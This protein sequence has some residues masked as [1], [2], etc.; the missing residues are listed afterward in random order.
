MKKIPCLFQRDFSDRRRPVLLPEVTP[1][2]LAKIVRA[3]NREA[4]KPG[5]AKLGNY[6]A[7]IVGELLDT[8]QVCKE[9]LVRREEELREQ[10]AQISKA[11]QVAA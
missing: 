5:R 2:R 7:Y 8:I 9:E 10:L 1:E 4:P 6:E 3:A 11:R